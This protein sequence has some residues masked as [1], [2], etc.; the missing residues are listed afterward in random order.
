MTFT[1]NERMPLA[2]GVI[3]SPN[4]PFCIYAIGSHFEYRGLGCV[5]CTICSA[6]CAYEDCGGE[7][8]RLFAWLEQHTYG[9][10]HPDATRDS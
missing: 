5:R 9:E 6:T 8:L 10:A 7:L 1:S 2:A 4:R 3:E